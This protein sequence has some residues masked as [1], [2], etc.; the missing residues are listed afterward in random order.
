M[1]K[2]F[3]AKPIHRQIFLTVMA[4]VALLSSTF[5]GILYAQK[6]LASLNPAPSNFIPNDPF[7]I[8]GEI[9]G[10]GTH[11]T[12]TD[13]EYLNI[14]L[15]STE[16]IDLHFTSKPKVVT[17]LL[18][19]ATS[20][21][22][23]TT[24][25][26]LS[27]FLKNTTYYKYD[28]DYHNLTQFT[29]DD[30][31]IYTYTQDMAINHFVFIQTKK[32]TKFI[33]DNATGG[34]CT[35]IGAWDQSTKTCTLTQDINETIQVD[36][37]GI[38]L[39]GN[40]HTTLS[41]GTTYL[42]AIYFRGSGDIRRNNTTIKNLTIDSWAKG[43]FNNSSTNT[44]IANNTFQNITDVGV[45]GGNPELIPYFIT[46][47]NNVFLNILNAIALDSEPRQVIIEGNTVNVLQNGTGIMVYGGRGG[48]FESVSVR[49][50]TIVSQGDNTSGISFGRILSPWYVPSLPCFR[51]L[52]SPDT[53]VDISENTVKGLAVGIDFSTNCTDVRNAVHDNIVENNGI[54]L[55]FVAV[56]EGTTSIYRNDFLNNTQSIFPSSASSYAPTI[57]ISAPLPKG[58][59]YLSD[60]QCTDSANDGFCDSP[61]QFSAITN[62]LY[63]NR[64]TDVP[65][66]LIDQFPYA[67]PIHA[68]SPSQKTLQYGSVWEDDLIQ[69]RRGA[70][71]KTNFLFKVVYTDTSASTP[72][73]RLV[74]TGPQGEIKLG[75]APDTSTTTP[76][77]YHDGNLANGE[78]FSR[79][80]TF[81]K[82]TYH[83]HFETED[84]TVKL[85]NSEY[86]F[87]TGYSNVAFLPGIKASRLF[88]YDCSNP[89]CE[90]QLWEPNWWTDTNELMMKPAGSSDNPDIYTK[91]G[92]AGVIDV[93]FKAS[94]IYS[95]FLVDL[96]TWK[97]DGM[98]KDY[99]VLAYDWRL[100]FPQIL[101]NGY[102]APNGH[103][104]YDD[105]YGTDK[106][107]LLTEIRNLAKTSDTGKVTIIGHSM[108]G[109]LSKKI[110]HDYS[111]IATSTEMLILVDSPQLGT[112]DA[113][114]T[115]LH[116]TKEDIPEWGG[117]LSDKETGRRVA[118]QMPSIY[119]LL[120]S[121]KYIERV[122]DENQNYTTII[123]QNKNL[124]NLSGDPIYD[125]S[126]VLDFYQTNYG[127]TTIT[128]YEGLR[129]YLSGKDYG[130]SQAPDDDL[131]HPKLVRTD[132]LQNAQLIHDDIDTWVPHK[133]MRVIQ[134][135]GW[136]IP[137]TIRGLEYKG[138]FHQYCNNA[139]MNTFCWDEGKLD[140]E[141]M[142]TFDGD[143][144]VVL[145]SQIGMATATETYFVDL[146]EHNNSYYFLFG[147]LQ[148]NR[149]HASILE[150]DSTRTLISKI[151]EN[152]PNPE[153]D[154]W[155]IKTDKSQLDL[156]RLKKLVRLS[157][158]SPVQ[159]DIF[160]QQGGH[161]GISA[162][163]TPNYTFYDTEMPN[164]YYLE[165]GEGKYLGFQLEASTTI[166]LQG[167]GTGVFTLELE[168]YQGDVKEASQTFTDIPVS[169]STKATLLMSTLNDAKEL[170]LDN[171]GNGTIDSIVF[172]EEN[173]ETITF[174]TLKNEIQKLDSKLRPSL[175]NQ[176]SVAEKQF[177]K[178]NYIATKALLVVLQKEIQVLSQKKIGNKWQIE[179]IQALRINAVIDE[180]VAQMDEF[181]Q[182]AKKKH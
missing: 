156:F 38:T 154:L 71:D 132:M 143:G 70:A 138:N 107:H 75:M 17:M 142:F 150:V 67:R 51:P 126:K 54:G 127:T 9:S 85:E 170:A 151:I 155:F 149:S 55:N 177:A 119:T 110:L 144:R 164:S 12:I 178:K 108:G 80:L 115:L 174:Q 60:N 125:A 48:I 161:V 63:W 165:M 95:S 96:E 6:T 25:I 130:R 34:D 135:A 33:K 58:G 8:K 180:L 175:L 97:T 173:K 153:K 133:S 109:L 62:E 111:D 47:R 152:T 99:R 27:G 93:G 171:D 103:I 139:G 168:Q 162:S 83:Y 49:K 79:T 40:G 26:T 181:I 92:N 157:L 104:Y 15:D 44:I 158:R 167:I 18:E 32:S 31:G 172:T 113:I 90:D 11:F 20:T 23:T 166:K 39:D 159:I 53:V 52:I 68:V 7:Q 59:N 46:I 64:P 88:K 41:D 74:F 182:P 14:T 160:N 179:K 140:V 22:A 43:I 128:A 73:I 124:R 141:P 77:E 21:N 134:I 10:I 86:I 42:G 98:M 122:I 4:I 13:S 76:I 118:Q 91:W 19:K 105:K 69:D 5:A 148:K 65:I 100:A 163:S 116:G 101:S 136:G 81:S 120:P 24:Q 36:D 89:D 28:D 106:E 112:P 16:N 121:K 176:I 35:L 145:P 56:N 50:N 102:V 82:G 147:G 3:L 114:A 57:T 78:A 129:D 131:S 117:I 29:T 72:H 61:Y 87:M 84:G 169:T 1:Y 37:N 30:N 137:D 66:T 146:N 123:S 2:K 94:N 45:Y